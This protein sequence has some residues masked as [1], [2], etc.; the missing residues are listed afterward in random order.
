MAR[1]EA[2]WERIR[3]RN[4]QAIEEGTLVGRFFRDPQADGFAVY[5]VTAVNGDWAVVERVEDASDY[6]NPLIEM[7][8]KV[9]VRYAEARAMID[10]RHRGED[11]E[12]TAG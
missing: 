8:G 12:R 11:A 6:R 4:A 5:Q 1:R 3:T 2:A 9:P 7:Q 10:R